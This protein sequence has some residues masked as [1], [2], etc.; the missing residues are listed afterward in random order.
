MADGDDPLDPRPAYLP[1]TF[2]P[3][4]GYDFLR[5][6]ARC[7]PQV[8]DDLHEKV[9][10]PHA[11]TLPAKFD[12]KLYSQHYPL[13]RPPEFVDRLRDPIEGWAVRWHLLNA[14]AE[15]PP[16]S[17]FPFQILVHE[18][19]LDTVLNW[20]WRAELRTWT[21][22]DSA[23]AWE[24]FLDSPP[25]FDVSLRGW[26]MLRETDKEYRQWVRDE[27]D[28]RLDEYMSELRQSR[29]EME[30]QGG[31]MYQATDDYPKPEHFDLLAR[32]QAGGMSHTQIVTNLRHHHRSLR[33]WIEAAAVAV[34]GVDAPRWW[35]RSYPVGR[36]RNGTG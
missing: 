16:R 15:R 13:D 36:P 22:L 35:L 10:Q 29:E 11:S 17:E 14:P 8:L 26:E 12:Y 23:A 19:A 30:D 9:Y 21:I 25:E 32:F 27:I 5:A 31:K 7:V 6:I 28:R 3:R 18:V 24:V 33:K 1:N 20:H 4:G 34:A 2:L